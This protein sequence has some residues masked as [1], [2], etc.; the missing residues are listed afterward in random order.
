MTE[1]SLA[2]ALLPVW[3]ALASSAFGDA[4]EHLVAHFPLDEG[5][6]R[7]AHDVAANANHGE[8]H[9]AT[10]IKVGEGYALSFDGED[11]YVKCGRPAALDLRD[12][13]TL[14]AWVMPEETPEGEVG[15][16]GKHFSSYLLTYYRNRK[17]YWY[18]GSGANNVSEQLP[19]GSW[20]HVAGAFDGATLRLYVNGEPAGQRNSTFRE[21][22]AGRGFFIGCAIADPAAD[23]PAHPGSGFFKGLIADVRVYSRALSAGEIR[24]QYAKDN[25]GRF[26][27][28]LAEC[29]R[30]RS[31]KLIVADDLRVL[32]GPTGA[33]QISAA[34]GYCIAESTF[35]YPGDV[36]GYNA[37]ARRNGDQEASWEPAVARAGKR[38][39]RVSARGAHYRLDRIV[40]LRDGRVE[41]QDTLA[42]RR[43]EPVGVLIRHEIVAPALFAKVR[44]GAGYDEPIVFVG[45]PGLDVG[46]VAEDDVSRAQFSPFCLANRTGFRLNHFALQGRKSRTFRWALYMLK[47]TGDCLRFINAVRR[48]W[49]TNHTILGPAS[50]FDAASDLIGDPVR[51]KH[52]LRRRRLRIAMLSP[53]LDY[54]PGSMDHVLPRDQYEAMMRRAMAALK[55]ADPQV[56]CLGCIETDWVTID[57]GRLDGGD[58]LPR[59]SPGHTGPTRID[60][61]LGKVIE[62]SGLPWLD[63]LKRDRHGR[64]FLEL[65][66]RGG[67]PQTALGV[68][69]AS[70]N[71]QAKFLMDQA[72][73]LIE[74]V[75]L[76]GFYID[77]FS[78]YWERLYD[79]WDGVTVDIDPRTGRIT[80]RYTDASLAGIQPR[81]EL[82]QYAVSRGLLMVANTY[83]TTL[84]ENRLPVMRFS[85]TW[86][87]FDVQSI[88]ESGKPRFV[89]ALGRGQLGTPI[90]LGVL[91]PRGKVNSAELLMRGIVL[92]LRHGM[93]YYHYFYG[94]VPESGEGSGEYG[95]INHMF[96]ITPRRLFEGGIE[97]RERTITCVSGTYDWR[98]PR[99]P[100][101]LAFGPDGRPK[102]ADFDLHRKGPAWVVELRLTDWRDVAVIEK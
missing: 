11:D 65:Y 82:C 64:L 6:G 53:W 98:H 14:S 46:I 102:R 86:G 5:Q 96:P 9:G 44:L 83:A 70:G 38:A 41:I 55:Q 85:E 71:Y 72:R 66:M 99:P 67:K 16:A 68:Y 49:R 42:S 91:R 18:I 13:V 62:N 33:M 34:D 93:T 80:R 89:A 10:W 81:L 101:V 28:T 88:P 37:L 60:P 17:T 30:I 78:Q 56:K 76:D 74:Q 29:P 84:R 31:G 20:S 15:I 57:P 75:G 52:Y 22:P 45:T 12:E 95:P 69:P 50:F 87:S 1:S 63:S 51:L 27:P 94:D 36:V 90:G 100:T 8:I 26:A 40:R 19:P 47:P 4:E 77:E 59:A 79:G 7:I 73:F 97:G 32:V 43:D 48:D 58:R 21:A 2:T 35:S 24:A 54:D 61:A 23:D 25:K 3:A 92:Y 39:I